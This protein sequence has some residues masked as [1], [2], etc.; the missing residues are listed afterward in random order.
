MG[1]LAAAVIG[2]L[3]LGLPAMVH[4]PLT[5]LGGVIAGALC[6]A[7]VGFLK[8]RFGSNEVIVSMML[9]SILLY[10]SS[11][12]VSGPLMAAEGNVAQTERILETAQ[13]PRV[14][15]Q[16]QLTL[17]FFLAVIAC[18]AVKFFLD[19]SVLGY[20]IRCC[21]YNRL[22]GETA[23]VDAGKVILL[24]LL[25][26]GAIGGLAGATHVMGVNRRYIDNFSPGY[27][28][29]GIAVSALAAESPIGVI[30]AGVVFGA[31][32]AGSAVLN[33]TT[34]IPTDFVDVI[35]S[36]VVI[37]VAA[38]LLVRDILGMN[39]RGKKNNADHY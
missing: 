39:R 12:L 4:I 3:D 11:Y 8:V 22:A 20:E 25:I 21:G 16:Y 7:L 31:L 15:S 10:L 13:L 18:I 9:N 5:L 1:A 29:N 2:T 37:F 14:F 38:P 35:Q 30:F 28:F 26:S 23:G 33:R 34:S 32:T 27:G 17:A 36:M 24:T 6:G 19:R